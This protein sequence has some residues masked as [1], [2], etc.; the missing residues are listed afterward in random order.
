MS[1]KFNIPVRLFHLYHVHRS[2]ARVIIR[3][4]HHQI[5]KHLSLLFW[6]WKHRITLKIYSG[7]IF[8]TN[9]N[10]L[11]GISQYICG[12]AR[13]VR[14][15]LMYSDVSEEYLAYDNFVLSTL[16]EMFLRFKTS[17]PKPSDFSNFST[18]ERP[19][20]VV[21]SSTELFYFYR[22]T[23]DRCAALSNR[24]PF[25]DLCQVYQKWL[26][27]Y[28]EEVLSASLSGISTS[29]YANS[30]SSDRPSMDYGTV[31]SDASRFVQ[32]PLLLCACA[33]LNTADYCA[34]T[35]GQLQTRLQDNI[36]PDLKDKVSLE[37]EQDLFRGFVVCFLRITSG[38]FICWCASVGDAGTYH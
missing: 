12:S 36:H 3:L 14:V 34:E 10:S 9:P 7:R 16:A 27:V 33:C 19:A 6:V 28:S 13:Q 38:I 24:S 21:P 26:K 17:R 4:Q 18:E 32:P 35:A 25:L 22:K 20:A 8:Y 31:S 37:S 30:A 11:W 29:N 5:M 15:Y 23:L 1:Q 2:S